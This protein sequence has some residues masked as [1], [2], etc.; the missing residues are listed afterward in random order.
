MPLYFVEVPWVEDELIEAASKEEAC[1]IASEGAYR[2]HRPRLVDGAL[3]VGR[4][5]AER[6]DS[7]NEEQ[8]AQGLLKTA[9]QVCERCGVNAHKTMW[10]PGYM[11]CPRCG[12]APLSPAERA[13][14]VL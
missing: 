4:I 9:N 2:R 3:F 5:T 11:K 12:K 8:I 1:R 10:G 13:D 14:G 6:D 7:K